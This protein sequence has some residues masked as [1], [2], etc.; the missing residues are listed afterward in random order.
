MAKLLLK[1]ENEDKLSINEQHYTTNQIKY[2][3]KIKDTRKLILNEQ[4]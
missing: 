4:R 3:A 2:V 1:A